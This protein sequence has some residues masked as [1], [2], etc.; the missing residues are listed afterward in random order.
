[1]LPARLRGVK[2][3]CCSLDLGSTPAPRPAGTGVFVCFEGG[4][5]C[6]KTTQIQ[7]LNENLENAGIEAVLTREP[8]GTDLGKT[9]RQQ[10]L[11][12]SDIDARTEALLYAADRA[13]HVEA[14]IRPALAAGR[15]VVSDRYVDSSIAYQ[16]GARG[17]GDDIARLADWATQGLV[18]DLTILLDGDPERLHRRLGGQ[19]DR[20][21]SLPLDF[22]RQVRQAFLDLAH[23]HPDRYVVLDADQPADALASQVWDAVKPLVTAGGDA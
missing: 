7:S 19:A 22:H 16:G 12:G 10:L 23:A 5:A 20:L 3:T 2:D 13:H 1:M 4:E 8:G 17:L 15:V 9:L 21:E 11:H 6:G 14:V 18:P